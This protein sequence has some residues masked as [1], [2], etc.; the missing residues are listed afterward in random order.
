[1]EKH[2]TQP[3]SKQD[4]D[5]EARLKE[6]LSRPGIRQLL[7]VYGPWDRY[8]RDLYSGRKIKNNQ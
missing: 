2:Q 4:E 8:I 7:E 1:M 5:R 6:A 3:A